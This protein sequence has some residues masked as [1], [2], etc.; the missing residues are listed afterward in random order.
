MSHLGVADLYVACKSLLWEDL[1]PAVVSAWSRFSVRLVSVCVTG[2]ST[3]MPPAACPVSGGSVRTGSCSRHFNAGCR[4]AQS[5]PTAQLEVPAFS[6]LLHAVLFLLAWAPGG[7]AGRS[8]HSHSALSWV[9][10]VACFTGLCHFLTEL[11]V[12]HFP[13]NRSSFSFSYRCHFHSFCR[14]YECDIV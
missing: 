8:H 4:V 13:L 6:F 9:P 14:F 12:V 11:I 1:F 7:E 10:L 2:A 3:G 5:S